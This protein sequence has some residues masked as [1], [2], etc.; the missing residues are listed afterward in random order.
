MEIKRSSLEEPKKKRSVGKILFKIIIFLLLIGSIGAAVYFYM[1]YKR[2]KNNPQVAG[3]DEITAATSVIGKFMDL[4]E[5][6]TPNMATVL[7]KEK[8]KDQDFFKHAENGDQ[9]L[10]YVKARKAI[11]Y[12]PST[13]RVIEFAPLSIGANQAQ[14]QAT[15]PEQKK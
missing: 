14:D 13:K 6:E 3:Q 9:I 11:L 10:I 1:G 15:A 8:L 12:R 5:G 7:D 2:L 4:P